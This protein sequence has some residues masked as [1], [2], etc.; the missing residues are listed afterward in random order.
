MRDNRSLL[1]TRSTTTPATSDSKSSATNYYLPSF[2]RGSLAKLVVVPKP[3]KSSACDYQLLAQS[4]VF[5]RSNS[6]DCWDEENPNSEEEDEGTMRITL[7]NKVSVV[8]V[9][10]VTKLVVIVACVN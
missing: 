4:E 7:S 2:L 1:L 3:V 10:G 6:G 8:I 5:D 9:G